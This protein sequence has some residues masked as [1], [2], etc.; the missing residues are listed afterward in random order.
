M[1][2]PDD[3]TPTDDPAN[4]TTERPIERP[5]TG[6]RPTDRR[7]TDPSLRTIPGRTPI[8]EEVGAPIVPATHTSTTEPIATDTRR[9]P[10]PPT[11]T[12]RRPS[13]PPTDG[14]RDASLV[15][16][17]RPTRR[18]RTDGGSR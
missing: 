14:E 10:S 4:R 16:D 15:P 17:L 8:T 2:T 1:T 9:R 12:R 6:R 7:D 11:D 18:P 5:R 3:T 13:P